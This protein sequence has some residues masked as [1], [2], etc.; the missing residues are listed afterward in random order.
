MLLKPIETYSLFF[1]VCLFTNNKI[2]NKTGLEKIWKKIIQYN[3]NFFKKDKISYVSPQK[4]DTTHNVWFYMNIFLSLLWLYAVEN[5][6]CLLRERFF[7]LFFYCYF[8][9]NL[10]C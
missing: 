6:N 1:V 7:S 9:F 3:N 10:D 8:I 4:K 5:F 2:N